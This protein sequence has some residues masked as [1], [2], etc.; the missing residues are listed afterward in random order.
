[1]KLAR[2]EKVEL[3]NQWKDEAKD[4][5][6]WLAEVENIELLGEAIGKK[7]RSALSV[8]IFSARIS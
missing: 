5:T 4:F 7:R 8:Q 2:L 3:R 1:M 6:P